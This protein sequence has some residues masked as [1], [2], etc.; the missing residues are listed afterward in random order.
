MDAATTVVTGVP[1]IVGAWLRRLAAS[2]GVVKVV[3][4]IR[5]VMASSLVA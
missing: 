3:S 5:A 2:A 1:L 4:A